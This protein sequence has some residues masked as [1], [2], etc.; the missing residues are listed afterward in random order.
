MRRIYAP[1]ET[2]LVGVEIGMREII[3]RSFPTFKLNCVEKY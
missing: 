3:G 1:V 2:S